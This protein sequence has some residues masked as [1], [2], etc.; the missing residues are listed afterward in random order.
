MRNE[1]IAP[2]VNGYQPLN[3][4]NGK[5]KRMTIARWVNVILTTLQSSRSYT[6]FA[7]VKPTPKSAQLMIAMSNIVVSVTFS[8]KNFPL[9]DLGD[10]G[11]YSPDAVM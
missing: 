10:I 6:F 5:K 4:D 8:Y 1:T 7:N 3:T 9:V 11:K 2:V